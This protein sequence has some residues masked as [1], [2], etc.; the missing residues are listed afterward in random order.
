MLFDWEL[1]GDLGTS[2][3]DNN[4]DP[5]TALAVIADMAELKY[6]APGAKPARAQFTERAEIRYTEARKNLQSP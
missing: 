6:W 5:D 2:L 4:V 1:A 3:A